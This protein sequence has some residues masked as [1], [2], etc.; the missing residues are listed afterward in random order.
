[1]TIGIN[2]EGRIWF[3]GNIGTWV[4]DIKRWYEA[5]NLQE[6]MNFAQYTFIVASSYARLARTAWSGDSGKL[7]KLRLLMHE[8]ANGQPEMT[9]MQA[10]ELLD[11]LANNLNDDFRLQNK[12]HCSKEVA[13]YIRRNY[14]GTNFSLKNGRLQLRGRLAEWMQEFGKWHEA[15]SGKPISVLDDLAMQAYLMFIAVGFTPGAIEEWSKMSDGMDKRAGFESQIVLN[16]RGS[17][18]L[19]KMNAFS[20]LDYLVENLPPDFASRYGE[21]ARAN[22]RNFFRSQ[23]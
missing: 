15:D 16:E 12:S 11:F 23:R 4:Q 20:L 6:Y 9:P 17:L 18:N 14:E 2:P 8:D 1:M 7:E 21:A 22:S 19:E 5:D 3:E 10:L 13:A